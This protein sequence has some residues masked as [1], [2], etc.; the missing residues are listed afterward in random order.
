[1]GIQSARF[2]E[3]T[4]GRTDAGRIAQ[5]F[6]QGFVWTIVTIIANYSI[7]SQRIA[8]TVMTKPEKKENRPLT[9]C[10]AAVSGRSITQ[11]LEHLYYTPTP[12]K[13]QGKGC[14][15]RPYLPWLRY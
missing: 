6:G 2:V 15:S 4:T 8:G 5:R 9:K 7:D 10:L 12:L 14:K 1:M 3:R 11:Y 13:M